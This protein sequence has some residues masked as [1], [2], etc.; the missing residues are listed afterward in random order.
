[1]LRCTSQDLQR[2]VGPLQ[3]K[4]LTEP[5]IITNHGRDRLVLMSVDEYM[6]LKKREKQAITIE[7][8]PEE[9]INELHNDV[10]DEEL[11]AL[12]YLMG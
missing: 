10:D 6:R 9:F 1:M 4:A 11:A 3:E 8:M 12:D 2:K 7:E 5:V